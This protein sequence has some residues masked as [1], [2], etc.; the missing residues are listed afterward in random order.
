M[1]SAGLI[2][3]LRA[4]FITILLLDL[5]QL[6]LD[7]LHLEPLARQNGLQLLDELDPSRP[8]TGILATITSGLI[9]RSAS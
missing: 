4:A 9:A 2:D 3:D 8:M 6:F 7:D 5:E 1:S